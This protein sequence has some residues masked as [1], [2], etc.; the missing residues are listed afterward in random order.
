VAA[1]LGRPARSRLTNHE[2]I[3]DDE[4]EILWDAIDSDAR[5]LGISSKSSNI[6]AERELQ[7]R[8][9]R[10]M[11]RELIGAIITGLAPKLGQLI[12]SA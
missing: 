11:T 6:D 3:S 5:Q 9:I 10:E 8:R 1:S 2:R 7:T 12:V 4:K